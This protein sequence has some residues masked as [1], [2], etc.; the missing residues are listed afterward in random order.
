MPSQGSFENRIGKFKNGNT[1][2]QNWGDYDPGNP[3]I[4]KAALTTHI[5]DV[6]AANTD[7]VSKEQTVRQQQADRVLL[8]FTQYDDNKE[9]GI[10]NP[11]CAQ[12]RIIGVHIFFWCHNT[13]F[14]ELII[15]FLRCNKEVPL[16]Q[17]QG[18]GHISGKCPFYHLESLLSEAMGRLVLRANENLRR[19]VKRYF[20]KSLLQQP[21]Q[22]PD[23]LFVPVSA[24]DNIEQQQS[25]LSQAIFQQ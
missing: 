6:E 3:F 21:V 9:V 17:R 25:I 7:V 20:W 12:E 24:P 4:T 10:I 16:I 19:L 15:F 14:L 8:C 18:C 22:F 5:T 1:L 11:N 23:L 2:I 13:F